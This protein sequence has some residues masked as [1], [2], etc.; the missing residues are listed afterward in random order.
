[1]K[2]LHKLVLGLLVGAMAIGFSAF[3]N[4]KPTNLLTT[5]SYNAGEQPWSSSGGLPADQTASHYSVVSGSPICTSSTNICTY[6]LVNG[7][8]EQAAEGTFE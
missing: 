5:Y 4:A 6:N 8:F 2:N 3:T 1:M 7:K